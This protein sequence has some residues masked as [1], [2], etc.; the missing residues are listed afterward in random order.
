MPRLTCFSIE[1]QHQRLDSADG[2][3][4]ALGRNVKRHLADRRYDSVEVWTLRYRD[5]DGKAVTVARHM[6]GDHAREWTSPAGFQALQRWARNG[7]APVRH[8]NA[9]RR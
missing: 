2:R 9:E 3:R 8:T 1:P 6:D 7:I 5:K 4:W